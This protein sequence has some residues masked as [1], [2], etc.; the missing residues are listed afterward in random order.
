VKE[1]FV[2]VCGNALITQECVQ[3]LV[4][5]NRSSKYIPRG[6]I[7]I[8]MKVFHKVFEFHWNGM[9]IV[10]FPTFHRSIPEIRVILKVV[11]FPPMESYPST[12]ISLW[13]VI[14]AIFPLLVGIA[15]PGGG[16]GTTYPSGLLVQ[17][18]GLTFA[19]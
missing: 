5:V 10:V 14:T 7:C 4:F 17:M 3:M 13:I 11:K 15:M 1:V 16:S 2:E 9:L 12:R 19:S 6:V 8:I 18:Q